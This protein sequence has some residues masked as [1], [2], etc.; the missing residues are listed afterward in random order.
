M[1]PAAAAAR[2]KLCPAPLCGVWVGS[3]RALGAAP[4]HRRLHGDT[5]AAFARAVDDGALADVAARLPAE[6]RRHEEQRQQH[7]EHAAR[8]QD[9]RA[10]VRL[11]VVRH[12]MVRRVCLSLALVAPP[13]ARRGRAVRV[14]QRSGLA[15][16]QPRRRRRVAVQAKVVAQARA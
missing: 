5:R 14:A 6:Q 1:R 12:V 7:L 3:L 8:A 4:A 10:V 13:L 2:V 9:A 11:A 16:Q 15:A